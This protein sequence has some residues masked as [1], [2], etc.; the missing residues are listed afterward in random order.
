MTNLQ[1]EEVL[2]HKQWRDCANASNELN[3]SSASNELNE[4]SAQRETESWLCL[5]TLGL[6]S[7]F[8]GFKGRQLR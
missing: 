5:A 6:E 2:M 8:D 1:G 3:E 4:S 7:S